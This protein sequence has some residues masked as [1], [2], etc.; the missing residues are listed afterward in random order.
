MRT[1]PVLSELGVYPIAQIQD[2]ARRMRDAGE[3]L[4]DFSIGDPRE[5]TPVF[6]RQ[7]AA[8]AIPEISQYPTVSGLLSLRA[9][10]AGYVRR[11]FGVEVDPATQ[12]IPTAGAKEAIF[13]TPFAFID[14]NGGQAGVFC[15]PGYPVHERGLRFAGAE[16]V[17]VKLHDDFVLRVDDVPD[18]LWRR[19]RLLWT[20]S[21]QNPTGAVTPEADLRALYE[22][23]C[24]H[25]TLLLSDE[26]YADMWEEEPPI[27]AL[28]VAGPGSVGSLTYLSCSKRS[29][30][31]GYRSGAIVGDAAAIAAL[32]D[33]RSSVGVG[34]PE[35]IQAAATAAWSDDAHA[36]GRRLIFNR[37]RAVL[38]SRLEAGGIAVVAS[39]AG[40]YLWVEVDD[41]LVAAKR[42][43]AEGVVVSPGSA[44][45]AGGE[46][47][48]RLALVPTL[49]EC[50]EAAEVVVGCLR[51]GG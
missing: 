23:C 7:A 9:A 13:T 5:P 39:H 14:P 34:S 30:M 36:E 15:T 45:G 11:R 4:I 24:E 49:E 3:R 25:D 28:Q 50:A 17:G 19:L 32:K 40:L 46:G 44:F 51:P 47:H 48:L 38:R 20:C 2:T 41:D 8:A 35:F 6:I 27:S 21:P 29:G 26:A 10:I 22:R 42:L 12:V 33:L 1:N 43:L 31:T 18:D 37:K 16:A